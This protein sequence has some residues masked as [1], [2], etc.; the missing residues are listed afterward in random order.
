MKI[1]LTLL[2]HENKRPPV[3]NK[4]SFEDFLTGQTTSKD[5]LEAF[6]G[7]WKWPKFVRNK[8]FCFVTSLA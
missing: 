4:G 1:L 6:R 2:P 7:I 3:N 8:A 5:E